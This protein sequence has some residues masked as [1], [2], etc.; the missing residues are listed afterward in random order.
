MALLALHIRIDP[1]AE[2]VGSANHF[3]MPV[4]IP[5]QFTV[6]FNGHSAVPARML[7]C[8][9]ASFTVSSTLNFFAFW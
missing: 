4:V 9:H 3:R 1:E 5:F 8:L 6:T 2:M 7:M